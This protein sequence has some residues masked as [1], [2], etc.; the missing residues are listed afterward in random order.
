MILLGL[1]HLRKS[2][3][4]SAKPSQT[5]KNKI[6][7]FTF[8]VINSKITHLYFFTNL[9][10]IMKKQILSI[11]SILLL[12]FSIIS[13]Q[14][15][16]EIPKTISGGVLNSKAT[17]LATPAYPAAA[18]AINAGGAVNV[19]VVIDENGE[20]ISAEA[21]SG[22][23]LLRQSAEK[24]ARESTFKPTL[25][26]G[27]AVKV[28]GVVVYNFNPS[29]SADSAQT[30]TETP[31]TISGG[32]LNGKATNLAKPSYPAAARAVN[33]SGVVSVQVT[34]DENGDVISATA[35]S[36][37]PLLRQASEQAAQ[38]SNFSP[39]LLQGQPVRVT[40]VIVY[41]FVSSMSL[42]QIGYELS[43]AENSFVLKN[44][45]ANS[46]GGSFPK[47]WNEEREDLK[48]L[49]LYLTEKSAK[50]RELQSATSP[51][52]VSADKTSSSSGIKTVIGTSNVGIVSSDATYSLD[53]DSVK[54]VKELQSKI[55]N[56]LSSDEKNRWSFDL[57]RVLGK[58]KAEIDNSEK[59]Q[60]N[61]AELN[62]LSFATPLG[63]SE[64]VLAKIKE[65]VGI[66]Q[67]ISS[68]TKTI[69]TIKI[70]NLRNLKSF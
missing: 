35:V 36:G 65:I 22:H 37:H 6:K 67:P 5:C 38:S 49:D 50:E 45:R 14:T 29:N 62:Q 28:T 54:I 64:S 61:I 42:T 66:S 63:I 56:R 19:Q 23:P 12:A 4:K 46:I 68:D 8:A 59:T 21:V 26:S 44:F 17:N 60:A 24:A 43:L 20:V 13:A 41:N 58:L 27:Q 47:E 10:K 2:Q 34:I 7:V 3:E 25:L 57:G 51:T 9:E 16:T 69:L 53:S 48:K 31:K 18:K 40:G 33:A 52:V 30:P 15:A 1:K 39:T 70:E 32:V 11:A 55:E